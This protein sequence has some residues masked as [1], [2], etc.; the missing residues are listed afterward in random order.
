MVW[1]I[2]PI[3]AGSVSHLDSES[4]DVFG[5]SS[6]Y[7]PI[8]VGEG[9]GGMLFREIFID[10]RRSKS[11]I[12]LQNFLSGESLGGFVGAFLTDSRRSKSRFFRASKYSK[13]GSTIHPTKWNRNLGAYCYYEVKQTSIIILG[14]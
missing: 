3:R 12:Y 8:S 7:F 5:P 6:L 4:Y 1:K 2:G 11:L 10:F 14:P 9:E 13:I